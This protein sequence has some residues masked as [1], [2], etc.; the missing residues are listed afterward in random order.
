M[1]IRDE[2]TTLSNA[3]GPQLKGVAGELLNKPYYVQV[4]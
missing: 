1:N 3:S 2:A 4:G